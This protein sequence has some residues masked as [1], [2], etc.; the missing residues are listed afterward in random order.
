MKI[1]KLLRIAFLL[2]LWDC[3]F[4]FTPV[5]NSPVSGAG[6]TYNTRP[7]IYFNPGTT[8]EVNDV[9][10]QI[11][12]NSDFSSPEYDRTAS[13]GYEAEFYPLPT[14]GGTIRH[15]VDTALSP[16]TYYVRVMVWLSATINRTSAWSASIT[17]KIASVSWTDAPYV[18][19]GTTLLKAAHFNEIRTVID[20]LRSFRG[21]GAYTYTN[22]PVA[23][24]NLIKATD[25]T[26]L[27][28][29]LTAPYNA[30]TGSDP[31]FTDSITG[32]STLIRAIHINELRDKCI[33]P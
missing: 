25:I 11:D 24:G 7:W 22:F 13:A 2:V 6:Q 29:A 31:T 12:N 15:R 21:S 26:E 30:A 3:V 17:M 28:T 14:S 10:I 8:S 33:L 27:R 19:A 23:S 4:A 32:G 18:T 9:R 1:S 20:N 5:I 16:G